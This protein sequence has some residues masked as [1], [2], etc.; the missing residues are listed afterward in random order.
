[1]VFSGSYAP[2]DVELLLQRVALPTTEIAEKERL[3]QTGAR[4]YSEMLSPEAPPSEAYLAIYRAAMAANGP[5]MAAA[6][7]A[8]AKGIAAEIRG[9]ITLVSLVRA[10]L[11]V[12]VLLRRALAKLGRPV[13]HYGVS[14]IR[15][16]GL[17]LVA[18]AEITRRH[19]TDGLIFVDGWTGK[20]AIAGQLHRSWAIRGRPAP[21][22]AVLADIGGFAWMAPSARDWLIPS[23]VLGGVVSGLVSRSVLNDPI[24]RSGGYHGC[25]DLGH[26]AAHDLT[27]DFVDTIWTLAQSAEIW[28]TEAARPTPEAEKSRRRARIEQ[29]VATLA[30]R[31]R[32]DNPNRI[33]PGIAEATRA[34]LR[35]RPEKVYLAAADSPELAALCHLIARDDLDH[36]VAPSLTGPY[37]AVTIIAK[38]S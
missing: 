18:M 34:V 28:P 24:R 33:K 12:G 9:E 38:T 21:R 25:V 10:G 22:L 15:D 20:G 14:I 31:H 26:L 19:G 37:R 3:I 27:R 35:R 17:D 6:V 30:E 32:I 36:Q 8:L 13:H 1:M 5:R 23:G 2:E 11:P 29:I 16:R 4:H 7:V